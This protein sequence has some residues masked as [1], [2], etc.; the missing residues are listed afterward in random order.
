MQSWRIS[1]PLSLAVLSGPAL[2]D[3]SPKGFWHGAAEWILG[4]P[5]TDNLNSNRDEVERLRG[6]L[7]GGPTSADAVVAVNVPQ[8][9]RAVFC[10][11]DGP[12]ILSAMLTAARAENPLAA[13]G[14]VWADFHGEGEAQE[15][16]RN[17]FSWTRESPLSAN[18]LSQKSLRAYYATSGIRSIAFQGPDLVIVTEKNERLRFQLRDGKCAIYWGP[19]EATVCV[20]A[21]N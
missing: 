10:G 15:K 12:Q 14:Q 3:E 17:F 19:D 21:F 4:K 9:V 16:W 18:V 8:V 2:A 5:A 13:L 6:E 11:A 1:V 7:P 20:Q